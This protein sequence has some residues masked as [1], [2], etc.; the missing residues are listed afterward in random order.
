[1]LNTDINF[2]FK[3]HEWEGES[4]GE[5]ERYMH[6]HYLECVHREVRV[7]E[8]V[9]IYYAIFFSFHFQVGFLV[10]TQHKN[11]YYFMHKCETFVHE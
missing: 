10:I 1:M 3:K 2:A 4:A 8:H 7:F 9:Q 6:M 5:E 11:L